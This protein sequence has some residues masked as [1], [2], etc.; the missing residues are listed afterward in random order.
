VHRILGLLQKTKE[1]GEIYGFHR[2]VDEDCPILSFTQWVLVIPYGNFETNCR[3]HL[4]RSRI[5][6]ILVFLRGV[7]LKMGP[8]CFP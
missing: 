3:S 7:A 4:H 5:W 8:V 2:D 6:F 1:G